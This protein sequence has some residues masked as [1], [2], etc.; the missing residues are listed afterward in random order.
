MFT[1]LLSQETRIPSPALAVQVFIPAQGEEA[2]VTQRGNP[3]HI[4]ARKQQVVPASWVPEYPAPAWP[5][6]GIWGANQSTES[7]SH[8]LSLP[9]FPLHCLP[10]KFEKKIFLR[11]NI[12]LLTE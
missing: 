1:G 3:R 5:S 9:L 2:G 6:P 10:D 11:L 8:A 12:K 7:L 4:H